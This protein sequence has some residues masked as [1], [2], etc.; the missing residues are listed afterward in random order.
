MAF[1]AEMLRML[2]AMCDSNINFLTTLII[3]LTIRNPE[4]EG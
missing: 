3:T 1:E 4:P 2:T